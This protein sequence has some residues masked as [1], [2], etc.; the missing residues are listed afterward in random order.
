M[1][2]FPGK[3]FVQGSQKL[4]FCSIRENTIFTLGVN[5]EKNFFNILWVAWSCGPWPKKFVGPDGI[6]L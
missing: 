1:I 6:E 3:Y 4:G 2:P 5:F